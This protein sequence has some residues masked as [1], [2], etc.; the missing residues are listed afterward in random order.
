M[1]RGTNMVYWRGFGERNDEKWL[2]ACSQTM[3]NG[4]NEDES[5]E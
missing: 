2:A 5:M 1:L 3:G 4:W